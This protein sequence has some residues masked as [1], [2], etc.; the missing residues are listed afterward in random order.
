[1]VAPH[2]I[3][4]PAVGIA[5]AILQLPR[6]PSQTHFRI[7]A[8]SLLLCLLV[9]WGRVAVQCVLHR[10]AARA[11]PAALSSTRKKS[12]GKQGL[13]FA[14]TVIVLSALCALG[15]AVSWQSHQLPTECER[16]E[17]TVDGVIKGLTTAVPGYGNTVRLEVRVSNI[18]PKEC[19]GP[20]LIRTYVDIDRASEDLRYASLAPRAH[21]QSELR[22]GTNL[23]FDAR[24]RRPWGTVN[25]YAEYGERGLITA[26]VHAIGSLSTLRMLSTIQRDARW[27]SIELSAAREAAS[28]YIQHR[29]P[30]AVGALLA[31][32]AVG[33]R[34]GITAPMWTRLRV[35]GVTHLMIISGMHVTLIALPG[36]ILGTTVSR[37]L[38]V[39][40]GSS[41]LG[42]FLPPLLALAF[43]GIYAALSG[44]GLPTQRALL[45]LIVVLVPQMLGRRVHRARAL[46]IA[47][48]G[49]FL[50]NPL[51]LLTASFW[52][53]VGSV[54]LLLWFA[55]WS[56]PLSW[57]RELW[58]AQGFMLLAMLPMGLFWFKE[59]SGI[60]GVLNLLAIPLVTV[61][62]VPLLL[63]SLV[64]VPI[65]GSLSTVLIEFSA[66]LLSLLWSA[67]AYWQPVVSQ[68]SLVR[69]SPGPTIAVFAVLGVLLAAM[70]R[71]RFRALAIALLLVTLIWPPPRERSGLVNL[72][73]FD[74]GQGTSIL[75]TQDEA[76]M[77]YDT[78]GGAPGGIT[79]AARSVVPMLHATGIGTLETLIIS[80]PDRDHDGGETLV[81]EVAPPA[82]VRRGISDDSAETCRLGETRHFARNVV[83]RVLSQQMKGDS[84]NNASCV[85]LI[86]AHGHHILLSGDIDSSR[87]RDLLA[88]WGQSL[89]AG[90]VLAGHHG[91]ASSN[92]RLWLRSLDPRL[93]I[94]TAG[95][96]NRFG[97]P[98]QRVRDVAL[99]Q[100]VALLNTA[101]HGAVI[102]SISPEGIMGCEVTRHRRSPFWRRGDA[103]RR[104]LPP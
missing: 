29:A 82:T 51:S 83:L 58:G 26:K 81:L 7:A 99:D 103:N 57:L 22:A 90:V 12:H 56:R 48:L 79:A 71:F 25:P 36:W 31:A 93:L 5:L 70:P 45:M 10:S 1:M 78:G 104:C 67:M 54:G 74:V 39:A 16:Q 76:A 100:G 95:H 44:F 49:L 14:T 9:C 66:L 2:V 72:V 40:T 34:R 88:Y 62:I 89:K 75:I 98:A 38:S 96:A 27:F 17:V 21:L 69:G 86:S 59:A 94:V 55:T 23:R 63:G 6:L 37:G 84:D 65:A 24:L 91:S 101:S 77:L 15:S 30:G 50:L 20:Q 47:V 32:L 73:F 85:L 53:T 33:D 41:R 35:Y 68:W 97:H 8:L 60:G 92:S 42:T 13:L 28:R 102:L 46:P 87:E 80:H 4:L 43:A 64:L 61:A 11:T 19:A 18:E 3:L 52:L